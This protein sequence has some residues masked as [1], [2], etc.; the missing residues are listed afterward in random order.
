MIPKIQK[1]FP[2]SKEKGAEVISPIVSGG[3]FT[4]EHITS[5]GD[6]SPAGFWYDQGKTEWVALVAGS[7]TLEFEEGKLELAAGDAIVI[8]PHQR[9]RVTRTSVDAA[10][11][12]LH[13]AP[14]DGRKKQ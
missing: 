11:I 10:W 4:L 9:H 1:L 6:A 5:Y 13:Y 8:A 12:A 3:P 2:Q 7:A 14:A